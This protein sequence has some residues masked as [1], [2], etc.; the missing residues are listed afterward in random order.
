MIN[1]N[2][3][4][5]LMIFL[6]VI[7]VYLFMCN[8]NNSN[9]YNKLQTN[10]NE[11]KNTI[12]K[13]EN[14][15]NLAC[16]ADNVDETG[17]ITIPANVKIEGNIDVT[18][19]SAVTGN[20]NVGGNSNVEGN[21]NVGGNSTITGSSQILGDGGLKVKNKI[22]VYK[23]IRNNNLTGKEFNMH[24][25]HNDVAI[26]YSDH[27]IIIRKDNKNDLILKNDDTILTKKTSMKNAIINNE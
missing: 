3:N 18:G 23:D 12:K 27:D 26:M 20:S 17:T 6:F 10:Y 21:S 11:L 1:E 13:M 19:N 4:N 7:I 24:I 16:I 8:N 22:G 25:S 14:F 2:T 9:R 5:V 15:S